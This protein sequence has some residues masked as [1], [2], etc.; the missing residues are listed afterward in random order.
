M[1]T[2]SVI[3]SLIAALGGAGG[4]FVLVQ[5]ILD[6]RAKA[7]ARVDDADER[8]VARLERRLTDAEGRI[9]SLETQHELDVQYIQVLMVTL[10]SAGVEVPERP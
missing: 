5:S 7:V 2:E 1:L 10:A 8:L 9:T 3:L 4:L 6:Y